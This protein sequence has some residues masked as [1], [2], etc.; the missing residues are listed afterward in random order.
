MKP[1]KSKYDKFVEQLGPGLYSRL[2]AAGVKNIDVAYDN[3][4]RQL[5]YESSYGDSSVARNQ[6]N[7]GGYGWNGKT[8]TTFGSDDKFLDAYVKLMT[9]RYKD[10][11]N[12]STVQDY[13]T[14]LKKRGYF[15]DDLD[16]YMD[17]L[18]G[19]K[20]LSRA[21]VNHRKLNPHLYTYTARPNPAQEQ[22][23]LTTRK[24]LGVNVPTIKQV[25]KVLPDT[26]VT[27]TNRSKLF[28][29]IQQIIQEA[30]NKNASV[31]S[32]MQYEPLWEEY[33][34]TYKPM[35]MPHYAGGKDGWTPD[36]G[37]TVTRRG[38]NTY[39]RL[40]QPEEPT[41]HRPYWVTA[42]NKQLDYNDLEKGYTA[43]TAGM[44]PNVLTAA[45]NFAQGDLESGFINLGW[46]NDTQTAPDG[47]QYAI[48]A[49]GVLNGSPV[50]VGTSRTAQDVARMRAAYTDLPNTS[51]GFVR[52][53]EQG[54]PTSAMVPVNETGLSVRT[55]NPVAYE[56]PVTNPA[57]RQA[58]LD[59]L[60]ENPQMKDLVETKIRPGIS[61]D[62]EYPYKTKVKYGMRKPVTSTNKYTRQ[63]AEQSTSAQPV[64]TP[65][66]QSTPAS[67]KTSQQRSRD[68][69][70]EVV[71]D[72][73]Y[74]IGK[75]KRRDFNSTKMLSDGDARH[76]NVGRPSSRTARS[77]WENIKNYPES[78]WR[79]MNKLLKKYAKQ[80]LSTNEALS[81]K[82]LEIM[83]TMR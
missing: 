80:G 25:D 34:P 11:V 42:R 4:I 36:Q 33:A 55:V 35:L 12:S 20:S 77:V 71:E 54:M 40:G 1:P 64:K 41:I 48:V 21:A 73:A 75:R 68:Y 32:S 46:T 49:P 17:Q 8:Y 9:T 57:E 63:A 2:A 83:Q 6:H 38:G 56:N 74:G 79:D 10:A 62:W 39:V 44:L 66:I 29:S 3:M 5:A 52:G 78:V 51:R 13:A 37:L 45:R 81:K 82:M 24:V 47:T 67:V 65:V 76:V 18:Q 69:Y 72:K 31:S 15:E 14:N 23:I 7:Y 50:G 22:P 27:G 60:E 53:L 70:R 26:V 43:A 16:H 58:A 19:M 59:F 30:S 28:P 61:E